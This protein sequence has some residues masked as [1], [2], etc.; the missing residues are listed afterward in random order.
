MELFDLNLEVIQYIYDKLTPVSA[1][2]FASTCSSFI[3]YYP[4]NAKYRKIMRKAL[5][6]I[7]S[8][9]YEVNTSA[10]AVTSSRS[11][12]KCKVV[13]EYYRASTSRYTSELIVRYRFKKNASPQKPIDYIHDGGY[14]NINR[15]MMFRTFIDRAMW[16]YVYD[17]SVFVS[18][19]RKCIPGAVRFSVFIDEDTFTQ[20]LYIYDQSVILPECN[21][22]FLPPWAD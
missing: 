21:K 18:L 7:D 17:H 11:K 3:S 1:A 15:F 8:I 20:E 19:H 6:E 9:N 16:S 10:Y 22:K 13:Y 2:M 4:Y 5:S 12:E 14:P